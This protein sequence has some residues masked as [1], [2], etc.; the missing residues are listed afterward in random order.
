MHHYTQWGLHCRLTASE[1][2]L[3]LISGTFLQ[4]IDNIK[5][6]VLRIIITI[7]APPPPK[8]NTTTEMTQDSLW[9]VYHLT[10]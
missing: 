8:K 7:S 1:S 10:T 3:D 2:A 5:I 6:S 4:A 9:T